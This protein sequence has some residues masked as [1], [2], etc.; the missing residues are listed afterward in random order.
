LLCSSFV[1]FHTVIYGQEALSYR[2]ALALAQ[3]NENALAVRSVDAQIAAVRDE[4]NELMEMLQESS[5]SNWP[6]NL[7]NVYQRQ[8]TEL[9][10]QILFLQLNRDI[11]MVG[12]ERSLRGALVNDRVTANNI[13]IAEERLTLSEERLRRTVILRRFGLAS[14]NDLYAAEQGLSQQRMELEHLR[15]T[16]SNQRQALNL[17]LHQ[18]LNRE[19]EITFETGSSDLPEDLER[20]ISA[21]VPQAPSIRQLQINIDRRRDE[22]ELYSAT[23]GDDARQ[24]TLTALTGAHNRA[25][26]ERDNA[27]C[28]ME[29]AIRASYNGIIQLRAQKDAAVSELE[30]AMH[31]WETAQRQFQLGR[32]TQFEVDNA[33]FVILSRELALQN[34]TYQLWLAEFSL[35]NP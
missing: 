34:I 3:E 21:A 13:A 10:R 19:I 9:E 29:A 28:A 16:A 22:R 25:V 2:Q 15:V 8:I 5:W 23:H 12:I 31:E 26:R 11:T 7:R 14:A 6:D 4:L 24:E 17:L 1:L 32:V 18:P 20:Y 27:V 35:F 33:R 30:R